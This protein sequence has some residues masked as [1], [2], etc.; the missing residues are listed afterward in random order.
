MAGETLL[1]DLS[2]I[3]AVIDELIELFSQSDQEIR[4]V[5][6][7]EQHLA[8]YKTAAASSIEMATVDASLAAEELLSA[9]ESYDRLYI[10]LLQLVH[11]AKLEL[12]TS[13]ND[14]SAQSH[15]IQTRIMFMS[16][17]GI[18][19]AIAISVAIYLSISRGLRALS[20]TMLTLADGNT[21]IGIPKI[22][23]QDELGDM[24]QSLVVFRSNAR[25]LKSS[26]EKERELNGQQRQFVSLVSHEFRTPL[27]IIDGMAQRLIRRGEK[28]P[29]D[30][31][32]I[33]LEKVR[34]AVIRLTGLMESVLS[35]ASLESGSVNFSPASV[36][37]RELVQKACESQQ[38]ISSAHTII[39]DINALPE[40]YQGDQKLLHQVVTN[41]LS[42]AV[43]YS[44]NADHVEVTGRSTEDG[45]EIAVRDFGLG[46]PEDE[47]PKLC[48]RFFRASTSTGIQG[49]GIGLN[50]VKAFVK[51]HGGILEVRSAEGEGSTFSVRLPR[52][53]PADRTIADAA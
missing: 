25:D 2:E 23:S 42:N 38:E 9:N 51:M 24:A 50:L 8:N 35:S 31:R 48:Q 11:L 37:L 40:T 29:V 53:L 5:Q 46:I 43:K 52:D 47:L 33:I 30:Q 13:L 28:T 44:P 10:D 34:N 21:E 1:T 19:A 3:E 14:L 15:E 12:S 32:V 7:V 39:N 45:V 41:L 26:L 17:L 36:D 4:L 27:A 49:T 18:A 20:N 22:A 6:Q 16:G